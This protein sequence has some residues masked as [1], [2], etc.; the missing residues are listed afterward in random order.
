[1]RSFAIPILL[2]LTLSLHGILGC[3]HSRSTSFLRGRRSSWV[4]SFGVLFVLQGL[5]T[6][7]FGQ[8]PLITILVALLV[9][10]SVLDKILNETLDAG[11]L[12]LC[13]EHAL[14]L[15]SEDLLDN[16]G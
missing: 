4:R 9:V 1:M 16:L 14:A 6:L 5:Q 13:L 7:F 12:F 10:W 8:Q 2:G 11:C 15:G 3:K